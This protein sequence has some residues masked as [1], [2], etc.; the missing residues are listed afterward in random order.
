MGNVPP[1]VWAVLLL[2][3]GSGVGTLNG[4]EMGGNHDKCE[5]LERRVDEAEAARESMAASIT[6][7]TDVIKQCNNPMGG[8]IE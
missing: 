7:L 2:G 3:G 5:E 4:L 6:A 1:W 8:W